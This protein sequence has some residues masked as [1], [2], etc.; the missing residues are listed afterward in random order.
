[1]LNS[2]TFPGLSRTFTNKFKDLWYQKIFVILFVN[3][4]MSLTG[5][6]SGEKLSIRSRFHTLL[7]TL[8]VL[9]QVMTNSSVSLV[10]AVKGEN[11]AHSRIF[12]DHNPNSRTFQGLE[13]PFANSRTFRD[14]QR[15]WQP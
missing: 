14:F 3:S 2:K 6:V 12:K 7:C 1:M 5:F 10:F 15:P 11:F 13:F 8:K 4:A 9:F